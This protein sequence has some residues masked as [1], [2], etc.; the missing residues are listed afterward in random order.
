MKTWGG[1]LSERLWAIALPLALAFGVLMGLAILSMAVLHASRAYVA[2]EGTWSKAQKDA[3]FHLLRYARSGEEADY[4]R[5]LSAIRVPLGDRI[6]R[7]ALDRPQ[8]D[9]EAARAG[10]LQGR[11]HPDD[12]RPMMNLFV[13]FRNVSY[14]DRAIGIWAEADGLIGQME[15]TA[16]ELRE[17]VRAK[18]RDEQRVRKIVAE[19]ESLDE[20]LRPLEDAFSGTLGEASRWLQG[21]MV[22]VRSGAALVFVLVVMFLINRELRRAERAEGALRESETEMKFLAQH[23]MLTGLPNRA[24]FQ[25]QAQQLIAQAGRHERRAALLVIDLYNFKQVNDS[26]G[27]GTGDALL[28]AAAK[29][30]RLAIRE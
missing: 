18:P 5:Y 20:R 25:E 10:F 30:L 1:R 27:H 15:A 2:G 4:G 29:R 28:K 14:L 11:N 12:V 16:R 6:A 23:D 3:T 24:M 19:V 21:L 7:E 17:A 22:K 13:Y 8:P 26:L 9:F